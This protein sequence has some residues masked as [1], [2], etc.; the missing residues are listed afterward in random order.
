MLSAPPRDLRLD[1]LRGWM[2]ISIFISHVTGSL[3]AWGIHASWGTSD[4]S[5]QFLFLSG[6]TL[7][8]VFALKAAR[9][10]EGGAWRDLGG[11]IA[12][13]YAT[14]LK[15]FLAF[16]VLVTVA[17][18]LLPRADQAGALGWCWFFDHPW[19][20]VI[21]A[22]TMTYQPHFLGI[23]PAFVF[24][25]L[26]LGPFMWLHARLGAWALLP[27]AMLWGAVQ[28][29][30]LAFPALGPDGLSF[31]PLA[32]QFLY[33]IGATMGARAL[34]R[35]PLP[36]SR[37][38]LGLALAVVLAGFV[39]ALAHHGFIAGHTALRDAALQKEILAWPRLLHAL[40]LAWLVAAL[41]PR[42]PSWLHGRVGLLLASL[43]ARSLEVFCLGLFAAWLA[44]LALLAWPAQRLW[45]DPMS[46]AA[47]V[48][49]LG[50]YVSRSAPV[51]RPQR[52]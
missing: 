31:D 16:A 32:W 20:G 8:S 43:G 17:Q 44:S 13:L 34:H 25:M 12:R 37:W 41:L 4:S 1:A 18:A 2:Q 35:R 3:F 28:L 36:R 52:S 10:G 14:Q 40:A 19:L 26:L 39:Q 22:L 27:S 50:L 29:G 7:G 6:F 5:E 11:R 51:W 45:L 21:G 38:L 49:A 33:L 47:G 15:L 30:W 24:S 46:I 48:T 23:L 42:D 9:L